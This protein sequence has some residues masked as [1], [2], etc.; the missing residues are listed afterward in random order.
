[1]P[2]NAERKYD[3]ELRHCIYKDCDGEVIEQMYD[4]TLNWITIDF[5]CAKCGREYTMK[6]EL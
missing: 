4:E 3:V 1:M 5:K 2:D 6:I